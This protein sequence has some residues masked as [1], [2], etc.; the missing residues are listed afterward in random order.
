MLT[1]DD[2][3]RLYIELDI[4]EV[5]KDRAERQANTGD[6]VLKAV[7]VLNCWKN[8]N[9]QK[10]TRTTLLKAL[11]ES[12]LREQKEMLEKKWAMQ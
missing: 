11:E 5:E 7:S 2:L 3:R 8:K 9:L 10:A 1:Y 4:D 6:N 12:G